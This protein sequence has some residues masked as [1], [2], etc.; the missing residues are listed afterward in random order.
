MEVGITGVIS[1]NCQTRER[2]PPPQIEK[3]K[4]LRSDVIAF[5]DVRDIL[6]WEFVPHGHFYLS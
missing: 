6:H 5:F 2:F 4:L 3:G 1:N